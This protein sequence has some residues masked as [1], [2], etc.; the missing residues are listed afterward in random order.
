MSGPRPESDLRDGRAPPAG[1]F[2][3][4]MRLA[5]KE[6]RET[7][8]DRRTIVTLVLMPIL[9]YPL[10]GVAF[11]KFLITSLAPPGRPVYRIAVENGRAEK[12][13]TAML[14]TGEVIIRQRR[15]D[16]ERQYGPKSAKRPASEL[17]AESQFEIEVMDRFE[18]RVAAG[19]VHLAIRLPRGGDV[20]RLNGIPPPDT[21]I[22]I[23]LIYAEGSLSSRDALLLAER[24]FEMYNDEVRVRRLEQ[25][26]VPRHVVPAHPFRKAVKREAGGTGHTIG[27]LIPLILILMTITGAVYPAIDLTAGER[28]R[29]TLEMLIAAPVPRMGLLMAKYVTVLLVAVLT[30]TMNLVS[31]TVTIYATGLGP[32]LFGE[33]GLS[34]IVVLQVFG[35]LVLLA[36]FFSAVLLAVTSFARSFKEAQAYLIP[37]M[38]VSIAPGIF[39]MMPDV[40]L[41]GWLVVVPLANIVLLARDLFAG[42]VL[43]LT[44]AVV[45]VSTLVYALAALMV[46]AR[47]FG[48]DAILY[49]SP[50]TIAEAL[51]RPH[52]ESDACT[53]LTAVLGLALTM[54][55]TFLLHH[56]AVRWFA[57]STE[58]RL[59]ASAIVTAL[60]FGGIP[61]AIIGLRNVRAGTAFSLRGAPLAAFAGAAVLGLSLWPFDY[62]LI[63]GLDQ[64]GLV[65]IDDAI[66]EK[67]RETVELLKQVHPALTIAALAVVPA[68][69]EEFFFRGFLLSALRTHLSDGR[70]ILVTAAVF[71]AVHVIVVP[72]LG[73][74]RL[75]PSFCM[76][77]VLGWVCVH[78]GSLFPGMLL[79]ALHNGLLLSLVYLED[80]LK[81]NRWDVAGDQHI[82]LVWLATAAVIAV[83]GAAIVY[84]R[85]AKKG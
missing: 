73:L 76:G 68:V 63:L 53:P 38:I 21:Q 15:S 22:P 27:A 35:L 12:T 72:S 41:G 59:V 29:G 61:L 13:V 16:D 55:V 60:A 4:L 36:M 42:D 52:R 48:T 30:A 28:E 51:R 43:P 10:L 11:E 77:L 70:S 37:L 26:G 67:G 57:G 64:L 69:C 5:L 50:G 1:W 78:T 6:M 49:G 19:D 79:H 18:E 74:E 24:C 39:S 83:A 84:V 17:P 2:G 75:L 54:P 8:R 20:G 66:R 47:V 31:M 81:D 7:L 82:P 56:F 45:I 34:V 46:A 71:G 65:P 33:G 14:N 9:V 23:E 3:R 85:G 25:R 32:L 62:E 44:A 80:W 40:H 58:I